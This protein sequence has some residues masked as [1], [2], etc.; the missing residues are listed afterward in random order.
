MV[1]IEL[2]YQGEL[3]CKAVHGPSRQTLITDAPVDNHGKGAYFS[4]TD[5][6]A[7]ALGSCLATVMGII[8][9]R[10]GIELAGMKVTVIKEMASTPRRK[11]GKLA[12]RVHFPSPLN[13]VQKAKLERAAHHCPVHESLHPDVAMPIE[14]IYPRS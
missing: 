10:E 4:P 13:D 14:F 7:T 12:V 11:I 8:A 3:R 2:D 6:V 1:Q 5:L 9:D